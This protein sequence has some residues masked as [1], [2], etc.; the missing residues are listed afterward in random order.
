M[1]F[2]SIVI[3]LSLQKSKVMQELPAFFLKLKIHFYNDVSVDLK[4]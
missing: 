4:L 1:W 2:N 3:D